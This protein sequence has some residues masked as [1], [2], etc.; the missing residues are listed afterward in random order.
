MANE[1]TIPEYQKVWVR[2]VDDEGL[3]FMSVF[4]DITAL[5]KWLNDVFADE[6]IDAEISLNTAEFENGMLVV[7]DDVFFDTTYKD[8]ETGRMG[9]FPRFVIRK[10]N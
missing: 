9:E 4:N 7:K 5:T 8:E 2:D 10:H 1:I 6:E 3:H